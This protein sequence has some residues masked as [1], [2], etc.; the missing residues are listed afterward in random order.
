MIKSIHDILEELRDASIDQRDKGDLFEKLTKR[1]L[2]VDPVY[3]DFFDKVWLYGEWAEE[4]GFGKNDTG[5]DLVARES[6]TGNLFAIQCKFYASDSY[7]DKKEIDSFFTASGKEPFRG[8][9]I[10]STTDNWSKNAED[11]LENQIGRA[12]V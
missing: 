5:I 8:R 2:E 11:A 1:W 12:H 9:I 7:L 3:R 10:F 4:A 6:E